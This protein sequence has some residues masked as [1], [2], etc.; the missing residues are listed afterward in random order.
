MSI[1]SKI[2]IRSKRQL[3]SKGEWNRDP[4]KENK[5]NLREY[6]S[7]TMVNRLFIDNN[8]VV[9]IFNWAMDKEQN[10]L[11][12]GGLI[13]GN[14]IL[15]DNRYELKIEKFAPINNVELQTNTTWVVGKGILEAYNEYN[16]KEWLTLGWIHTHPGH[17][18]FL[19]ET[20]LDRT[21]P[22]F[23]H[24]YQIAIV[25]DSLTPLLDTGIFCRKKNGDMNNALDTSQWISWKQLFEKITTSKLL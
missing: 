25:V 16:D 15:I 18:P 19:S 13:L 23:P 21:Q 12:K 20:D 3:T 9:D 17:S 11:E 7:D 8:C 6:F 4:H 5:I 1:K 14:Y 22:Y 24:D 2:V 10:T